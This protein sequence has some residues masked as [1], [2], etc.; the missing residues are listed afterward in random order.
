MRHAL[1]IIVF[2]LC[3][4]AART[5]FSLDASSHRQLVISVTNSWDDFHATVYRFEQADGKWLRVGKG[6]PAV[7][8]ERGLA[9]DPATPDRITWSNGQ[10][11]GRSTC[12]SRHI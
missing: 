11:R 3:L 2:I 6:V 12:P 1:K 7:T 9:W 10:E 8:G 4:L 5:G